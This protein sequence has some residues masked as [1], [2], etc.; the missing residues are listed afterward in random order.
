MP[1]ARWKNAHGFPVSSHLFFSSASALTWSAHALQIVSSEGLEQMRHSRFLP[2]GPGA[3]RGFCSVPVASVRSSL[4]AF[5]SETARDSSAFWRGGPSGPARSFWSHSEHSFALSFGS[6]RRRLLNE[7]MC[8]FLRIVT[9]D[10]TSPA[11]LHGSPGSRPTSRVN[12]Q[13]NSVPITLNKINL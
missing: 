12:R 13:L 10:Q 4:Q 7:P 1:C 9:S 6:V 3:F 2:S 8:P 5:E 11:R